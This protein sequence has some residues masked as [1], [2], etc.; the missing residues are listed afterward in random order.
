MGQ[1]EQMERT[2]EF[3]TRISQTMK[4]HLERLAGPSL[5]NVKFPV[6]VTSLACCVLLAERESKLKKDESAQRFTCNDLLPE[7]SELGIP[8]NGN[9]ERI[10]KD[11]EEAGYIRVQGDR[12]LHVQMSLLRLCGVLDEIFPRMQG[13][14]LIAYLVQTMEEVRS[15]RKGLDQAQEQLDQVLEIQGVPFLESRLAHPAEGI[16]GR[17]VKGRG[18]EQKAGAE[19]KGKTD[20]EKQRQ[21]ILKLFRA[22]VREERQ[23]EPAFSSGLIRPGSTM[24]EDTRR[25]NVER[26]DDS[27]VED[28]PGA[29]PHIDRLVYDAPPEDIKVYDD[30]RTGHDG[31]TQQKKG[32]E[33]Q[34]VSATDDRNAHGELP[35]AE[36]KEGVSSDEA[37]AERIAAFEEE[38][39]MICPLC[40][41]G[42]I[43]MRE[44]QKGKLFYVCSHNACYFVSWGKPYHLSCPRCRNS[45]LIEAADTEGSP[46]LK[47][48]RATCNYKQNL[49]GEDGLTQAA[50]GEVKGGKG[51]T[52]ETSV[53][54]RKKKMVRRRLVRIKR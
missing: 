48:P 34:P 18:T 1:N 29:G 33:D 31:R 14:N 46:F 12:F 24:Q 4:K 23:K 16:S 52:E 39:A 11:M 45:F 54:K 6:N 5:P 15:G 51:T 10:V 3:E 40:G 47:C 44:T 17:S 35:A 28:E 9:L 38:L 22:A 7:I 50:E 30:L 32:E 26:F 20:Q 27:R 8:A 13:I 43:E 21:A 53:R 25:K 42:R 36:K 49:P 2:R 37:I 41:K 19:R